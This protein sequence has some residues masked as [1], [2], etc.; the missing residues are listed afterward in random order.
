MTTPT[1]TAIRAAVPADTRKIA[2]LIADSFFD[3]RPSKYLVPDPARRFSTLAA[4]F[5]IHVEHAIEGG[6]HVDVIDHPSPDGGQP[7]AVAVWFDYTTAP[8]SQP[9]DYDR[10][11][12]EATGDWYSRFAHLDE[13][14]GQDHPTYP[15]HYLEFLAVCPDWQR[16]GLG[17]RLLDHHHGT[18]LGSHPAYLIAAGPNSH[19]LYVRH[20]YED[21]STRDL[22]PGVKFW[23]MLRPAGPRPGKD[24]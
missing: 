21:L 16:Q 24:R 19:P 12:K 22:A 6:G 8:V 20:G 14:L 2:D 23:P 3:L 11:L 17:G 1:T 7:V 9:P 18:R 10:Q 5:G 15:H 4:Q 13:V